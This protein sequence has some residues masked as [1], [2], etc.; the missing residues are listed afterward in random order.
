MRGLISAAKR[1]GAH[2]DAFT[3]ELEVAYG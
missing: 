1:A 3:R 2:P